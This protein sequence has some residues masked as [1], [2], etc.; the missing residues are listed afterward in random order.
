MTN[1]KTEIEN[2]NQ[3]CV[4]N[5]VQELEA[6]NSKGDAFTWQVALDGRAGALASIH[7]F[8]SRC[9]ELLTAETTKRILVPLECAFIL[10]QK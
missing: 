10:L 4:F 5:L 1:R 9:P 2:F 8:V 7:S 6:E 3:C